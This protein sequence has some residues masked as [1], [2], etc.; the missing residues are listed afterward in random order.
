MCAVTPCTRTHLDAPVSITDTVISRRLVT[1]GCDSLS[2]IVIEARGALEK[3]KERVGM[4]KNHW[5]L[6]LLSPGDTLGISLRFGNT[7]YGDMLDRRIAV[8]EISRNGTPLGSKEVTGFRMSS[9]EFNSLAVTYADHTLAI[10]GG[11]EHSKDLME[12]AIQDF[13][14]RDAH[15]W[16]VGK[17]SLTV[18]STETCTPPAIA[19]ASG[20]DFEDLRE[21]LR[22][23]RDP[24]EG[25]WTYF[26]RSNDPSYARLGGRYT[27]AIVKKD[28]S[29]LSSSGSSGL[30]TGF[31]FDSYDII[32]ISGAQTLAG[33]WQPM[34]LKGA[35][36]STIFD[37]HYDLEWI[38]STMQSISTD[39]HA[40]IDCSNE[41]SSSL[42]GSLLT[43]SFPLLKTT[44]RFSK[45]PLS[46]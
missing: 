8:V 18:F 43:L 26:D 24:V 20:Y 36:R 16:S 7:D 13:S 1:D 9:N 5:G 30:I 35:L 45:L 29:D 14:P 33:S 25:F 34:M 21:R 23:S 41:T 17:L 10:H 44:I 3:V 11:G 39:I 12:L 22:T 6:R 27:L 37:G 28:V 32:Y 38:D 40:T 19:L 4:S 2:S 31:N 46:K 15:I 42:T